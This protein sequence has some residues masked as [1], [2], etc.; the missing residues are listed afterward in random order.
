ML[1]AIRICHHM[2]QA[3]RDE[4]L[5]SLVISH[6][7]AISEALKEMDSK[8]PSGWDEMETFAHLEEK[9]DG[10]L[11]ANADSLASK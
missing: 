10:T 8:Y 4:F 1:N 9:A 5:A 2:T 6:P 11:V 3:A 7:A